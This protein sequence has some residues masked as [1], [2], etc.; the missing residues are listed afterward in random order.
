MSGEERKKIP[1]TGGF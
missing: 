1:R